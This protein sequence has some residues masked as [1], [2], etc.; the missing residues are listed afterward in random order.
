MAWREEHSKGEQ[1][2]Q[3]LCQEGG[4]EHSSLK[5]VQYG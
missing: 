4:D 3:R 5:D 1:H 2:V